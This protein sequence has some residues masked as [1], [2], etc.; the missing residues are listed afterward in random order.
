MKNNGKHKVADNVKELKILIPT[1]LEYS[2]GKVLP[3][4]LREKVQKQLVIFSHH[5]KN[6]ETLF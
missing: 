3:G 4:G 2:L 6:Y 5:E 1:Y